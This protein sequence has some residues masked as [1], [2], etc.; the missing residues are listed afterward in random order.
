M[1]RIW[2]FFS[3]KIMTVESCVVKICSHLYLSMLRMKQKRQNLYYNFPQSVSLL[4]FSVSMYICVVMCW[5]CWIRGREGEGKKRGRRGGGKGK[6]R[7][8]RGGGKGKER[9]RYT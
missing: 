3:K 9:G 1:F 5:T 4:L 8:R 2:R 6:E 7:G